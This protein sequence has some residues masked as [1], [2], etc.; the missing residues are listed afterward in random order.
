[1]PNIIPR[2][3]LYHK[4]SGSG[5]TRFLKLPYGSVIAFEKLPAL[6]QLTEDCI[7]D[8]SEQGYGELV[9]KIQQEY[10]V[11]EQALSVDMQFQVLVETP[12]SL[13]PVYLIRFTTIDPPL[14]K[15]T[16]SGAK[17]I[18]L[19]EAKGLT[20]VELQLLEIAYRSIMEG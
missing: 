1:M 15:V 14:G 6:S 18:H 12:K 4:Q 2:A 13:V 5:R 16:P 11:S 17:F 20:I 8:F 19:T 3:I 10:T 9:S 7:P